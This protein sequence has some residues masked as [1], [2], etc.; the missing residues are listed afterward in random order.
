MWI[1]PKQF[2]VCQDISLITF[3]GF[4]VYFVVCSIVFDI[5]SNRHLQVSPIRIDLL[6]IMQ[7][8]EQLL[9]ELPNSQ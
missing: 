8:P 4:L 2:P 3:P 9:N 7:H 1:R 6:P 5:R